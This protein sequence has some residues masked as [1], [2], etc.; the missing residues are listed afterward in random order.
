MKAVG[1]IMKHSANEFYVKKCR[2]Y[3]LVI[4]GYDKSMASL[5]CTEQA[6]NEMAAKLNEMRNKRFQQP[7]ALRGC[8]KHKDMKKNIIKEIRYKGHVITMFADVFHQEF[9]II[10]NDESTLYDSIADAKRVIRGEQ[11][12]YEVR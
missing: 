5:E 4:D 7:A 11:P 10:D 1:Y 9:A 12:Y 3:Y 6:A 2:G 8:T